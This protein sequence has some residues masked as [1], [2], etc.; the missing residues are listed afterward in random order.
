[1][2]SSDSKPKY[3]I[4]DIVYLVTGRPSMS[5]AEAIDISDDFSGKYKCQ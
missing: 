3:K 2:P 5:V 4:G 1:M